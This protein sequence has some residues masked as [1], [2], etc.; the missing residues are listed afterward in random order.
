MARDKRDANEKEIVRYFRSVGAT[1]MTATEVDLIV[2]YEGA[3]YLLEVKKHKE[4]GMSRHRYELKPNQVEIHA[5]W[6]GQI[7]VIRDVAEAARA[8]GLEPPE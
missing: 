6:R 3:N 1:V 4:P 2:G 7:G 5:Q 8:I